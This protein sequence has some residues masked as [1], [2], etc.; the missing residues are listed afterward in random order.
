MAHAARPRVAAGDLQLGDR[1]AQHAAHRLDLGHVDVLAEPGALALEKRGHQGDERVR[2]RVGIAE[3][4]GDHPDDRLVVVADQALGARQA[5]H[6]RRVGAHAAERAVLADGRH[7]E[8]DQ[9]GV[10]LGQ[11]VVGEPTAREHAGREV[12]D[13]D[14]GGVDQPADQRAA[15]RVLDVGREAELAVV[16]LVRVGRELLGRAVDLWADRGRAAQARVVEPPA[17]LDL[18]HLGAEVGQDRAHHRGRPDPA[19]V[20]HADAVEDGLH[21]P[22]PLP[23]AT[24]SRTSAVCSPSRGAG[25]SAP[26]FGQAESA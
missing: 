2:G 6:H 3:P 21:E 8:H 4:E 23:T 12:L 5:G 16:G 25:A 7:R 15:V 10:A 9:A 19:E 1:L 17:V 22:A 24:S 11:V 20:D 18:D 13:Q 14:V 26:V